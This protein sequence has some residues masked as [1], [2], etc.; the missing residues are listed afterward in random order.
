MKC[1]ICGTA[2]AL[3]ADRCPTCG[4]RCRT[5]YTAPRDSSA[6][7]RGTHAP[8]DPPNKSSKSK[9][10]CCALAVV[11]PVVIFLVFLI[12]A[13]VNYIVSDIEFAVPEP[14][15]YED[16][17]LEDWVPES[18]PNLADEG[19][20]AVVEN[21]LMF[22]PEKWD[23]SPILRIPETI[24]GEQVT[25]I[26]PGCFQDCT[27][28]TTILLP[29]S[30]TTI[31]PMAFSGCTNLRG[32][33]LPDGTESI[34]TDAFGGCINLEAI[35]VPVSVEHIASGCFDD[36]ASLLYIFYG[37]IFEDWNALYSGYITPFTTAVCL[38]GNYYHGSEG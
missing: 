21:T 2:L 9:G 17:P 33:F 34:G 31:G 22:L 26:G 38:D 15:F 35:Y 30:V 25:H 6:E 18:L 14:G 36:C 5:T 11:I 37:G 8:Y 12:G 19:C 28:L 7:Y 20:F 3:N 29:D 13:A 1:S 10:C 24:G 4:C 16:T 32:L 27:G 23:G